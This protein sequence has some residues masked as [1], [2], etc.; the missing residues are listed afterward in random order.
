MVADQEGHIL[1]CCVILLA[2]DLKDTGIQ[3]IPLLLA[4]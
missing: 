1:K 3:G 4:F 2:A